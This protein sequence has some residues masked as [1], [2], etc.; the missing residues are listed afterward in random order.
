MNGGDMDIPSLESWLAIENM[1]LEY[2]RRPLTQ[3]TDIS[4]RKKIPLLKV[5]MQDGGVISTAHKLTGTIWD[6]LDRSANLIHVR[7]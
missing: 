4:P 3:L 5:K 1:R 7:A 2:E 6:E